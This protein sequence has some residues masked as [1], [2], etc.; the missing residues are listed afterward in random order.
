VN[1]NNRDSFIVIVQLIDTWIMSNTMETSILWTATGLCCFQHSTDEVD[2]K[3]D[4]NDGANSQDGKSGTENDSDTEE[5][6]QPVSTTP[7]EQKGEL[8]GD[9][10][11]VS[12]GKKMYRKPWVLQRKRY[13]RPEPKVGARQPLVI[14]KFTPEQQKGINDG[15]EKHERLATLQKTKEEER[16]QKAQAERKK[17][18]EEK[19]DDRPPESDDESQGLWS[20]QGRYR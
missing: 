20:T 2:T 19:G 5:V 6:A 12:S 10:P 8:Q 1:Q 9:M 4:R 11:P 14:P 7:S 15:D 18:Q 16:K 3:S 17:R 13:S